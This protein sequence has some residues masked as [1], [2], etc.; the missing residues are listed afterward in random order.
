MIFTGVAAVAPERKINK[1]TKGAGSARRKGIRSRKY[2]EQIAGT[3]ADREVAAMFYEWKAY[4]DT[5]LTPGPVQDKSILHQSRKGP[6]PS[7]NGKGALKKKSV[8]TALFS[9]ARINT[10][11]KY[12]GYRTCR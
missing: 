7:L 11:K 3:L 1:K 5:G 2:L 9:T 6:L 10:H 8:Y 12:P 4:E